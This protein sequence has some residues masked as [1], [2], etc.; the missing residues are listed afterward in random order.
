[1]NHQPSPD[2]VLIVDDEVLVRDLLNRIAKTISF[3]TTMMAGGAEEALAM[4]EKT[5][6]A[7]I[8]SDLEMP[9]KSGLWLL[10]QLRKR[11]VAVPFV[12][13]SGALDEDNEAMLIRV[14]ANRIVRKPAAAIAIRNMITDLLSKDIRFELVAR[15]DSEVYLAGTFNNWNPRQYRMSDE[16]HMGIFS[17]TLHLPRGRYEYKFIVD[18]QWQTD[19]KNHA[20]I[21]NG[22]SST[23]NILDV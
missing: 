21:P 18:G 14:G 10:E 9:G 12:V 20:W 11:H 3:V 15:A 5:P 13:F 19:P 1:M 2:V 7:L 4:V 23:N 22:M 17:T 6:P 8:I 16:T